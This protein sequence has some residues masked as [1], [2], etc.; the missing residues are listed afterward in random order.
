MCHQSAVG[1]KKPHSLWCVF[2][3]YPE[4]SK[5]GPKG[6]L[7]I[8]CLLQ[9]TCL[10]VIRNS[11]G[12]C[13]RDAYLY[14]CS[15]V[16]VNNLLA[17]KCTTNV[18]FYPWAVWKCLSFSLSLFLVLLHLLS[19]LFIPFNTYKLL[20]PLYSKSLSSFHLMNSV[21]AKKQ[22]ASSSNTRTVCIVIELCLQEREAVVSFLFHKE[23]KKHETVSFLANLFLH[24]SCYR[25]RGS[26]VPANCTERSYPASHKWFLAD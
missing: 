1:G 26:S 7:S 14:D 21:L 17:S 23:K 8:P 6:P 2:L 5:Q 4:F 9:Q 13:I 18:P 19:A 3:C 12:V 25:C 20:L 22:S 15:A 16:I 11:S 24:W 10:L